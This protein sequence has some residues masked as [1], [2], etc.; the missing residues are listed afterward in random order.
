MSCW[1]GRS[2]LRCLTPNSDTCEA[3]EGITGMCGRLSGRGG[4]RSASGNDW[5]VCSTLQ[6]EQEQLSQR[7]GLFLSLDPQ[8]HPGNS[9][10][11]LVAME[12]SKC[13]VQTWQRP[14][15]VKM[16]YGIGVTAVHSD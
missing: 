2:E 6:K 9:I 7:Q 11:E 8:S 4:S 1:A 10:L 16:G 14:V 3:G 5:D 13:C 12:M 15:N